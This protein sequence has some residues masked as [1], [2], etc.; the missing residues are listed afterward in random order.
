[1]A[2]Y[3]P[4]PTYDVT[5]RRHHVDRWLIG[6]QSATLPAF[7]ELGARGEAIR[8]I[9]ARLEI[10]PWKPLIRTSLTFTTAT[11]S[12]PWHSE[13]R[14]LDPHPPA[15]LELFDEAVRLLDPAL[16]A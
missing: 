2:R 1:M 9:F 12:A 4:P 5:I 13:P 16:A 7:S 11:L 10:P 8:L 14:N 3:R 6:A 15:Q